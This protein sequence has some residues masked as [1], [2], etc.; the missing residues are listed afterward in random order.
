M[1]ERALP[2][3]PAAAPTSREHL[4]DPL[5]PRRL[6]LGTLDV[7]SVMVAARAASLLQT[8][9][10]APR[11]GDFGFWN[12]AERWSLAAAVLAPFVFG[13]RRFEYGRQG[14]MQLLGFAGR[15]GAFVALVVGVGVAGRALDGVPG[16]W[17]ASW[18]VLSLALLLALRSGLAKPPRARRIAV[19]GAGPVADRIVDQLRRSRTEDFQLL[20]VFDD[21]SARACEG[22]LKA[23]GTVE[24][25]LTLGS[26]E[27]IDWVLITLPGTAETRVL[28]ILRALD[29]LGASVGLS[30][31][32]I[33]LRETCCQVDYVCE[34]LP[35]TLL[36]DGS[37]RN[38]QFDNYDLAQFAAVAA[39]YGWERYGYVVTPNADHLIRLHDDPRFRALYADASYVLLDSRL[40]SRLLRVG[41]GVELPVCTGSDLTEHLFS[42]V[43][44]AK[45]E[46]V[47]IGGSEEQAR[48]LAARFG[49]LRLA[50]FNPP[51]GFIGSPEAV[52]ECLRFVEAHSPF[53][54]CFIAVGSP[55]QEILA[56]Q[57]GKRSVARGLAFCIGAS[58]DFLTGRERR[59][60][61]WMQ[62]LGM[63]WLYR[64]LQNPRRMA[65][66]YLVRGPRVFGLLPR[67]RF[68]LRPSASR[69]R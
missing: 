61:H 44:A 7:L 38:L 15:S 35:V 40:L 24:D 32:G 43:I 51:M 17:L 31:Q 11:S 36:N 67:T 53:R 20:G 19:V 39:G 9:L 30:P 50:H 57:L 54:F 2:N 47:L 10:P 16:S 27:S 49:L 37:R 45:D 65:R 34:G 64:L 21:R 66:R 18:F 42:S 41:K 28:S 48:G 59:A 8:W 26:R 12:E 1:R 14:R 56:Q 4:P 22:L 33:G 5:T 46:V 29:P 55:Q 6:L 63:E 69:A 13:G 23:E 60:P 68:L 3:V 58:I 52:E 62:Q 25:L